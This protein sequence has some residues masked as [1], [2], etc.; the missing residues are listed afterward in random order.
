MEESRTA[1]QNA[2]Q[3][4]GVP[5]QRTGQTPAQNAGLRPPQ[6]MGQPPAPMQ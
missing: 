1:F 2:P 6:M 4:L 3:T 5:V